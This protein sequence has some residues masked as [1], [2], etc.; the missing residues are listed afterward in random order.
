M[1][2]KVE[3]GQCYEFKNHVFMVTDKVKGGWIVQDTLTK[4]SLATTSDVLLKFK[5]PFQNFG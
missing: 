2:N 5:R 3:I 1:K 4:I